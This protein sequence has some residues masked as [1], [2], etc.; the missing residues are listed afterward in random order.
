MKRKKNIK[1]L[2]INWIFTILSVIALCLLIHD[3]IIVGIKPIFTGYLVG[4]T[5]LG[6]FTDLIAIFEL[7][8]FEEYIREEW[9]NEKE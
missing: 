8:M 7:T 9:F 3:F 6:V 4:L 2:I 1:K 5:W